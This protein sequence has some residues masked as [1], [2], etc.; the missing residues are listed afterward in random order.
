MYDVC[1]CTKRIRT[2]HDECDGIKS[3]YWIRRQKLF[4]GEWNDDKKNKTQINETFLSVAWREREPGIPWTIVNVNACQE[5]L[6]SCS[7]CA[8]T[9]MTGSEDTI[10]GALLETVQIKWNELWQFHAEPK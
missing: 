3:E 1:V 7:R 10:A 8:K 2:R 4:C 5:Y 6:F 9:R